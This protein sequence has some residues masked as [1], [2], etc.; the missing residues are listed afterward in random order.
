MHTT[1]SQI[2]AN[3]NPGLTLV[4]GTHYFIPIT[5]LAEFNYPRKVRIGQRI[6]LSNGCIVICDGY[7][8]L[9]DEFVHRIRFYVSSY[10][11]REEVAAAILEHEGEKARAR[12]Q[13]LRELG[14]PKLMFV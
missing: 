4:N 10:E 8:R 5:V 2:P 11:Q 1:I 6:S 3:D 9:D 7:D 14:K 12:A 13:R